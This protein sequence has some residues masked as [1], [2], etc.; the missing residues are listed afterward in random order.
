M[1]RFVQLHILTSYPPANLNRDE[2]G[3]PKTAKMGGFDRLRISSQCL[4]RAW[5]TSDLFESALSDHIGTRTKKIG[6]DVRDKLEAKGIDKKTA[7]EWA[8]QIAEQFGKSKKA[9]EKK[10]DEDLEIEQLAHISPEEW[11]AIDA[12]IDVLAAEKREPK[13]EELELLRK[14]IQAVDIAFFGRMLASKPEFNIEAAVQVAHAITIHAAAVEDDYFTAVDDLKEKEKAGKDDFLNAVEGLN[15]PAKGRGEDAGAAHIGEG[16]FG[17]GV[18]YVYICINLDLLVENLSGNKDLAQKALSAFIEAV[19]KVS[20][21]GKQNS[22]AS[23]AY[24]SY[25]MAEKGSQQPRSL[26]SAFLMPVRVNEQESLVEKGIVALVKQRDKIDNAYGD[27]AKDRKT[28]N[29]ETGEGNL[30]EIREFVTAYL[31][32]TE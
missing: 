1:S 32:E 22:F 5:R 28:M 9:K 27:C 10:S 3:R 17:A 31:D 20:P 13:K 16:Y 7:K 19:A 12:L 11:Q 23:R 4:K 18:F 15:D 2:Q 26:S 14:K 30:Q 21:P 29:V 24:A 8:K 25:I 6:L